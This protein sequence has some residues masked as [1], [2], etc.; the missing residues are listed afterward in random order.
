MAKKKRLALELLKKIPHRF[1]LGLFLISVLINI[2]ALRHNN[3]H[4]IYLRNQLY[5]ADKNNG[6]VNKALNNLREYVYGHMNTDLSTGNSTIKPP[7]QLKYTYQRLL[8]QNG[9]SQTN[10]QLYTDAENYCQA[11]VPNGFYGVYRIPCVEDYLSKHGL[12]SAPPPPSA[13]LY[14]FDFVSPRWS[15]DFAGW[16]LVVSALL[17]LIY[18]FSLAYHHLF[19]KRHRQQ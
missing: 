1:L 14:E 15:P 18:V 5:A 13:A 9:V 17:F 6:D 2:L 11:T 19:G 7:I 4:M 3:V 12:Q 8:A 16:S 10:T